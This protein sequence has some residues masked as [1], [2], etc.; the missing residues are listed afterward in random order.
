MAVQTAPGQ[1]IGELIRKVQDVETKLTNYINTNYWDDTMVSPTTQRNGTV[2]PTLNT[3]FKGDANFQ[4]LDFVHTQADEV[5][6][7]IQFPHGIVLDNSKKIFPHIHFTIGD[8]LANGNYNVQF[9]LEYYWA[10]IEETF[11]AAQTFGMTKN[12]T[13]LSNNHVWKHFMA[14][15]GTGISQARNIS[16]IMVCRLYRNNSVTSNPRVAVTMLGFD[17]HYLTDGHG[18]LKE[19]SKK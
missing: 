5:Q 13:V 11:G 14:T 2:A 7:I 3:G 1:T 9:I 17:I 15:N 10:D 6:F 19:S 12:F 4:K 18:S 8:N 16:S